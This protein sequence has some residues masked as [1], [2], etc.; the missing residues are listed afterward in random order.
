MKNTVQLLGYP[1]A[2]ILFLIM[3]IGIATAQPPAE[4]TELKKKGHGIA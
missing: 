2:A 1:F 3:V 4:V